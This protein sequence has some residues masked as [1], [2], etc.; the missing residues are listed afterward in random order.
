MKILFAADVPPDPDSGAAGTEYQ[1]IHALRQLGHEVDEIWADELP[2]RIRHGNLHYLIELPYTYR[3]IIG[4]RTAQARY[5]VIH[6][7][8]GHCYLAATDHKKNKRSGVF[9]CRSHGLDDHM[10]KVLRHWRKVLGIRNRSFFKALPGRLIDYLLDRHMKLATRFVDG[11]IVSSSLDQDYLLDQHEMEPE[12]V[13][14][15]PQAPAAIFSATPAA[16]M[17]AERCHRVL[18]AANYIYSKGPYIVAQAMNHLL[19]RN[20]VLSF[21]WLCREKDHATVASLLTPQARSRTRLLGWCSQKKLNT[22]YDEH[23]IFLYP[24]FFDGFGKV[25][26]EAMARGLCVIGT[27]AGGMVDVIEQGKSGY[28]VDFNSHEAIVGYIDELLARPDAAK[29]MAE[30]AAAKAR[31]YTWERTAQETASFYSTLLNMKG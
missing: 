31:Q 16:S 30:R 3:R 26:L 4:E 25:F 7:N 15:I 18:Y 5:D 6:A 27:R 28:L 24:S 29:E 17:S 23:G 22:I 8:Q 10:E 2:R 19:G 11:F 9:V 13:A 20:N 14:C 21:T 12:R 1:T